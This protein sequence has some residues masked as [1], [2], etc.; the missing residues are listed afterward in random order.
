MPVPTAVPP[1]GSSPTAG[2]HGDDSLDAVLDRLGVAAELLAEGHGRRVHQVGAAGLHDSLEPALLP[3]Q[4][5]RQVLERRDQVHRESSRV[6]ARWI[7]DGNTSF[8][9]CDA[10]T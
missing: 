8:D 3:A 10:L 6:A 2:Q 9:D 1:R 7:A 4:L 5:L